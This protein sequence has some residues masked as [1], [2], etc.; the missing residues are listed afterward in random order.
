MS[1]IESLKNAIRVA[2][3]E[4]ELCFM[5]AFSANSDPVERY[6]QA[7]FDFAD[8]IKLLPLVGIPDDYEKRFDRWAR[9]EMD[10]VRIGMVSLAFDEFFEARSREDLSE[11]RK[12]DP[13]EEPVLH[14]SIYKKEW[15]RKEAFSMLEG[16]R[17]GYFIPPSTRRFVKDVT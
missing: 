1:I 11:I 3:V 8:A 6:L 7:S 10:L 14:A 17:S 16:G 9:A 15:F 5:E 2:L 4:I 12:R 13:V